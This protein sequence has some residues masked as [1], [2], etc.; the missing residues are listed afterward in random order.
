MYYKIINKKKKYIT[1]VADFIGSVLW[2]PIRLFS[3]RK[4]LLPEDV[5]E[6]LVIRTAYIGDVVMTLPMLKP[7][8]QLYPE[9]NVT[10]LT[11]SASRELFKNHPHVNEILVYDAFWFYP[12]KFFSALRKYFSFLKILRAKK[13][14]L[15]VE[16]RG[17]I[18]DIFALAYMARAAYKVSYSFGGGGYLLNHVVAFKQIK[19]KV[20]YHI[21]IVKSLGGHVEGIEWGL[22]L[23]NDE[24]RNVKLL[25]K[26][27]SISSSD[28]A[29]GLHPGGRKELKCWSPD[30]FVEVADYLIQNYDAKVVFS[31][32]EKDKEIIK[33]ITSRMISRATDLAGQ[34]NLRL[35]IGLIDNYDLFI[36]NDT[37]PL[38]I[39]SA[40]KTPVV[41]IFGPS[42]SIETAPYGNINCVVEKDFPCRYSCDENVCLNDVHNECMKE[43]K[44]EDVLE[45]TKKVL[46]TLNQKAQT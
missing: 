12:K 40:M 3:R 9:A 46:R 35:L 43:I 11:S 36:C 30:R 45:A 15:V 18:R 26:E 7:L 8:K 17:D 1:V 33:S 27:N 21:D 41:A 22:S 39:A 34:T 44:T 10:F 38:H 19:H 5:K 4:Q 23:S 29:V 2:F 13:Y 16:A 6:I 42:K 37:A 14:D 31:G 24:S 20:D 25:L 32:S 28:L